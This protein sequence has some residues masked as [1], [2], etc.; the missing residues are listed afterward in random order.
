MNGTRILIAEEFN[1]S[2]DRVFLRSDHSGA[3]SAQELDH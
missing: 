1:V 3:R 2:L